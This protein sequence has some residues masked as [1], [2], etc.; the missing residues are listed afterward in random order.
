MDSFK[1]FCTREQILSGETKWR[2][3]IHEDGNPAQVTLIACKPPC[4]CV[5]CSSLWYLL[6]LQEMKMNYAYTRCVSDIEAVRITS[7]LI[8]DITTSFTTLQS[9]L[10]TR[11]DVVMS[12]WKKMSQQKRQTLI[13]ETAPHLSTEPGSL[14]R[15][16]INSRLDRLQKPNAESTRDT[17]R[18]LLLPWLSVDLL[19]ATPTALFALLHFRTH[20][21]P[22]EWAPWDS[23][24]SN[25]Q[26]DRGIFANEFSRKCIVMH[27]PKYGEV[28]EWDA[29]QAHRANIMGFPRAR[30]VLKAQ[31][32]LLVFLSNLTEKILEGVD[33]SQP[34]RVERW[35]EAAASGFR[36]VG[37]PSMWSPYINQT[38]SER[39]S[40]SSPALSRPPI[41]DLDH[42][43]SLATVQRN[44]AAD[45]LGSLRSDLQ[46]AKG[47]L[48]DFSR[49]SIGKFL[50]EQEA[51][52][53]L[54]QYINGDHEAH[55][56]WRWIEAELQHV[57]AVY[58]R[59][60][61]GIQHCQ[62]LP[63]ELD[64]AMVALELLLAN[65]VGIE[66][67][68][69]EK[70]IL[71]VPSSID[72]FII[73]ELD[74]AQS[75]G[76]RFMF[77]KPAQ[78]GSKGLEILQ[79]D[80]IPWCLEHLANDPDT[81]GLEHQALF[82]FLDNHLAKSSS[83]EKNKLDSFI[84]RRLSNLAAAHE[85]YVTVLLHRPQSA[86]FSESDI[87]KVGKREVWKLNQFKIQE[88]GNKKAADHSPWLQMVNCC[89]VFYRD[90]HVATKSGSSSQ[91]KRDRSVED[92]NQQVL[93][94]HFW[95][96]YLEHWKRLHDT[97]SL[98][99]AERGE[100][101]AGFEGCSSP[102]KSDAVHIL[103]DDLGLKLSLPLVEDDL[104]LKLSLPLAKI[105]FRSEV[106]SV[107][108]RKKEKSRPQPLDEVEADEDVE[109]RREEA[110]VIRKIV[111]KRSFQ[112]LTN[113]YPESIDEG[114]KVSAW[115]DLVRAMSDAGFSAQ[116]GGGSAVLFKGAVDSEGKI[117]FHRPHPD[118]KIDP[119]MLRSMGKR[120]KKWF[121]WGR[122]H[123][124]L[125]EKQ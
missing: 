11:A 79:K 84:L 100:F 42:L 60:R 5:H 44:E 46:Y 89:N 36:R 58:D 86:N 38:F 33:R 82:S 95:A 118:G 96:S 6:W 116:N 18:D 80:P 61:D 78:K 1:L 106:V 75:T 98:N 81:I 77:S 74:K 114:R 52:R 69:L 32:E 124:E 125:V 94:Q 13:Q 110:A 91:Q 123:F 97:S 8:N 15:F 66:T 109:G 29:K 4:E 16:A 103:Q 71:S 62:A 101:W 65:Q 41:L 85:I 67:S 53:W 64:K 23:R 92:R 34:I 2:Y 120:M 117:I 108:K 111:D 104:G 49:S 70:L 119:I 102:D 27:G 3:T 51:G 24:Q 17:E 93:L 73:E 115:D 10:D 25:Y 7:T 30:L 56:W 54:I 9:I 21:S 87:A 122:E 107:E 48:K 57:K 76:H 37:G 31:R 90:F 99:I 121:G 39:S 105:N 50:G 28:V 68:F 59:F 43:I 113:M 83:V 72:P 55:C 63:P 45:H 88:T 19:T 40:Y 47:Y 12:P 14:Y 112:I 26:W 20:H 22:A 35:R